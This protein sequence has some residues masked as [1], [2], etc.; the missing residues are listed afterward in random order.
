MADAQLLTR[1]P[2]ELNAH[3]ESF[4]QT[5]HNSKASIITKALAEYIARNEQ[6]TKL[7]EEARKEADNGI[8][9]SQQAI[10][11]WLDSWGTENELPA[12]KADVFL[13][14]KR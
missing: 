14:E 13:S 1:I 11:T 10:E 5:S 2:E 12:P 6:K 8:F 7:L 4:I 9:I 3:L